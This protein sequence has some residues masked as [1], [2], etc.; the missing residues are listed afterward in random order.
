MQNYHFPDTPQIAQK[1]D[2]ANFVTTAFFVKKNHIILKWIRA[3]SMGKYHE[4]M[5]AKYCKLT[6]TCK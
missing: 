4:D 3:Y 1:L 6:T 2:T 5:M